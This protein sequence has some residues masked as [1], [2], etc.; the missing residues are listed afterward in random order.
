MKKFIIFILIYTSIIFSQEKQYSVLE[1]DSMTITESKSNSISPDLGIRFESMIMSLNVENNDRI[2][3]FPIN[4]ELIQGIRFLQYYKANIRLGILPISTNFRADFDDFN[5]VFEVGGFLQ[6][7]F[8]KT[9]VYGI[10][11]INLITTNGN[12]YSHGHFIPDNKGSILFYN[13]GLGY[14]TSERINLDLMYSIPDTKKYGHIE[15]SSFP[16]ESY[17]KIVYRI[18]SIGFQYNFIF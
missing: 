8:L 6:A 14:R 10:I 5:F 9:N 1:L 15:Y 13:F 3:T 4:I 2:T 7:Y 12:D 17:D 16:D 18:V 11:G